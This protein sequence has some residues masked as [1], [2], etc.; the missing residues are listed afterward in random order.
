[1]TLIRPAGAYGCESWTLSVQD[2]NGLL[3]Y[4]RQILGTSGLKAGE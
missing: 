3:V 1:M 2:V 4:E